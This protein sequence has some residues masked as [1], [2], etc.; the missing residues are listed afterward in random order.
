MKRF[1]CIVAVLLSL[2]MVFTGCKDPDPPT[3]EPEK[4]TITFRADN[5][6]NPGEGMGEFLGEGA[7]N[8][9]TR[10]V[11]INKGATVTPPTDAYLV[12]YEVVAWSRNQSDTNPN[13][14]RWTS[15]F[16]H[17]G[18]ATYWAL[19]R[20]EDPSDWDIAY[21]K[22][23]PETDFTNFDGTQI[24]GTVL[25]TN[26]DLITA[27]KDYPA[28]LTVLTFT[29]VGGRAPTEPGPE[30][31]TRSGWGIG[32]LGIY[33]DPQAIPLT[34]ALDDFMEEY[35][36]TVETSWIAAI[37]NPA[38]SL[39]DFGMF[40]STE[41]GDRLIDIK[42]Y[43]PP[44]G[45]N[46]AV[47][48][49]P[50]EWSHGRIEKSYFL[51]KQDISTL[52]GAFLDV[53]LMIGKGRIVGDD[54]EAINDPENAGSV[55]RF[56]L[57]Q[58]NP[59]QNTNNWDH[60][61]QV[62]G[63]GAKNTNNVTIG[64]WTH[65]GTIPNHAGQHVAGATT[66]SSSSGEIFWVYDVP[67][68][69]L[70][71]R[72]PGRTDYIVNIFNY[73]SI[74]KCELWIPDPDLVPP[75]RT[76]S[77]VSNQYSNNMNESKMTGIFDYIINDNPNGYDRINKNDVYEITLEFTAKKSI[78]SMLLFL[79]GDPWNEMSS[80]NVEHQIVDIEEGVKKQAVIT[81]TAT[82][83]AT[84]NAPANNAIFIRSL[85]EQP[86]FD[87]D[88][89]KIDI[90]VK[91][92]GDDKLPPGIEIDGIGDYTIEDDWWNGWGFNMGNEGELDWDLLKAAK[93]LVFEMDGSLATNKTR[94]SGMRFMLQGDGN[95]YN[96]A[97]WNAFASTDYGFAG[98]TVYM[99]IDLTQHPQWTAFKGGTKGKLMKGSNST[100]EVIG[101]VGVYLVPEDGLDI[102]ALTD[103]TEWGGG[104]TILTKDDLALGTVVGPAFTA[105]G[106]HFM[107][108]YNDGNAWLLD[109]W[110]NDKRPEG[111][112][113]GSGEPDERW[114]MGENVFLIIEA[115][116]I[117]G[118]NGFGGYQLNVQGGTA[119]WG[120]NMVYTSDWTGGGGAAPWIDYDNDA[121][122]YIV[123][124]LYK[125]DGWAGGYN[126]GSGGVK[127]TSNWTPSELVI[128][129]GYIAQKALSQPTQSADVMRNAE[130]G[131]T[132]LGWIALDV[133]EGR[134]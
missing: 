46:S 119:G 115:V 61:G 116:V 7:V 29:A 122:I 53:D 96:N 1:L 83:W 71:Q 26:T 40:T 6:P 17:N 97:E 24:R 31:A 22:V 42:V 27:I 45:R 35:K 60:L 9:T 133:P 57:Y 99:I 5:G 72:T 4:V 47:R 134:E 93:Y 131:G 36:I 120:N 121:I 109:R 66:G 28:G 34:T 54:F 89:W 51:F 19:Y 23:I 49:A 105:D 62:G 75:K 125:V 104:A 59:A 52:G 73:T 14:N 58:K 110:S 8:K 15:D 48:P 102:S 91:V 132:K 86:A 124:D 43:K 11:V 113:D 3:P 101:A 67:V 85:P 78:D 117:A 2:T 70:K 68:N 82:D 98:I 81:L 44:V 128:K 108:G 80:Q 87:I 63:T 20:V 107:G 130:T 106:F 92:R 111:E 10:T 21:E 37:V 56:Y 13:S 76:L 123:I 127:L 41:N 95:D 33:G 25:G 64:G 129:N 30:G 118:K 32:K 90:D 114:L 12:G 126:T 74:I 38:T 16:A 65:T 55:L 50:P 103:K 100:L 39:A 84:G 94:I 69:V 77:H 79:A 88:F 112:R 18:N